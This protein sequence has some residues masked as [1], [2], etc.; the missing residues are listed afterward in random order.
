MNNTMTFENGITREPEAF[1]VRATASTFF[2]FY[3][4]VESARGA[5]ERIRHDK[6]NDYRKCKLRIKGVLLTQG[7]KGYL[8]QVK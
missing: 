7:G 1:I 4:D 5:I 8:E 6:S 3:P 2:G